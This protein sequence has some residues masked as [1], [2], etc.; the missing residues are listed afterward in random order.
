[1]FEYHHTDFFIARKIHSH[2]L[3]WHC[4][5]ITSDKK[6]RLP[7]TFVSK[8]IFALMCNLVRN[9]PLNL[10]R[11]QWLPLRDRITAICCC[12]PKK[13]DFFQNPNFNNTNTY[14][15]YSIYISIFSSND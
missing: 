14:S 15:F 13:L 9:L 8:K 5:N 3:F 6:I 10:K 1:M 2:D 4:L 12:S 7:R 11:E